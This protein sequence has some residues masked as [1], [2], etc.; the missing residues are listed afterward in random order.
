MTIFQCQSAINPVTSNQQKADT[1]QMDGIV[2]AIV[3]TTATTTSRVAY[4]SFTGLVLS[5]LAGKG[6]T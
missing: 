2:I 4:T 5:E 3:I 1:Q 6:Q